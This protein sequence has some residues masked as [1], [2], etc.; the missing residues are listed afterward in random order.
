VRLKMKK[1]CII[2]SLFFLVSCA[3]Q[4]NDELT[5]YTSRQPQ[6]LEPILE[7]FYQDTGIKVNLLS[8]NAQE[9]MERIVAEGKQSKADIFMTVDAGVLWQATD[10][11]IFSKI[12]SFILEDNIPSY[13]R[14]PDSQWFGLSK[15]ARTIVYS[16]D[17]FS[18][19]D[20]SSYEDLAHPKW[21]GKLCLRTSKKVYNRSLMAS[22][23][24]AYGYDQAKEIVSGWVTNLATE[25]FSN[26]TNAL[27]AVSSGQCGVTIVNTY[28]LARL[29]DDP[30][31]DNLQ[32]FWAN[33][34]G[35]G[36]HV[37][38]SGAGV[39]KTSKNKEN[40]QKLL[41]YLSSDSAQDFYASANKEYPVLKE[42]DIADSINDWG[43]FIEDDINVSKLG[44]LQKEAVF[45]AQEVGYK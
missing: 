4:S 20:F 30:K 6:L 35:R 3:N 43:S 14:D 31:Y 11:N 39:V 1:F 41:E 22:M 24:D 5:I 16:S 10:R 25:V 2:F 36:V 28:Y 40:A 18:E 8:G 29:L 37:N 33:Q 13:L 38:I 27:K 23:I 19:G 42:A 45:L 44:S 15:R 34:S 17:Q 32:L 7:N 9:L 12:N 26:D 21:R